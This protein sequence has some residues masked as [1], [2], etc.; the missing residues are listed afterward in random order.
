MG[1]RVLAGALALATL[2]G[3]AT[4]GSG[5]TRC[6][7]RVVG[8]ERWSQHERG[9]DVA[10]RVRGDAGSSGTVWLSARSPSGSYVSGFGVGVGPGPFEAIVELELNRV[11]EGFSAVLEV[12]GRRCRADA[13]IPRS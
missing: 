4:G 9:L 8:T 7:L 10:Y 3:C 2:A 1:R 12:A 13:S 6:V 11:P 5:P